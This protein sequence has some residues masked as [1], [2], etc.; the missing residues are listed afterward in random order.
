MVVWLHARIIFDGVCVADAPELPKNKQSHAF[1]DDWPA[2]SSGIF[3]F[4][5]QGFH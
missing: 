3:V 1:H 2:S 4:V 5:A